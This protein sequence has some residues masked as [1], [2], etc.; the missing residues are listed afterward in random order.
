MVEVEA[1]LNSRPLCPLT[2]ELDDLSVLTPAHF[3]LGDDSSL[4]P[5]AGVPARAEHRLSRFQLLQRIRDNFWK[6]WSS[7]YL[8]HLQER[9]KWRSPSENFALGQLVLIKD[10]RYPPSQWALGRVV[11]IVIS[12]TSVLSLCPHPVQPQSNPD[13]THRKALRFFLGHG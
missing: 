4:I 9:G 13:E 1:C 7:E 5:D 10:E 12:R 6:R 11:E 8:Q 3:L 2:G